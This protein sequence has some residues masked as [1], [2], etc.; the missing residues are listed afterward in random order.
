M[1]LM[2]QTLYIIGLLSHLTKKSIKLKLAHHSYVCLKLIYC[3]IIKYFTNYCAS[4]P[5]V[6]NSYQK[7]CN[8]VEKKS[9]VYRQINQ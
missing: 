1:L 2:G 7:Q 5:S 4:G 3:L 9:T 6:S 8:V